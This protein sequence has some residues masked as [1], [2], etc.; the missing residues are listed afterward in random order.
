MGVGLGFD[1]GMV[2]DE[3]L[4]WLSLLLVVMFVYSGFCWIFPLV[5]IGGGK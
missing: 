1:V 2:C 5:R 4:N 3:V